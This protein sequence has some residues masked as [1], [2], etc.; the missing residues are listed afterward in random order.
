M[1][2]HANVLVIANV[3]APSADLLGAL[4]HRVQRGPISVTLLMP[5]TEIGLA[6]REACAPRLQATIARWRE[7]GID[8][9]G[10]VGD[11]DPIQAVHDTWDPSR[12]DE[13]IVS[14]LP[15]EASR[16]TRTDLPHRIAAFTG[17]PV[18]HVVAMDLGPEPRHGPVPERARAPLGPLSVLTW[19][20]RASG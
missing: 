13:V 1:A 16:W 19:G 7:A 17:V 14:T 8:A 15:G 2:W 9:D 11:R 3:T 20:G 12:F 18:T 4:E 10:V 5:A 6:G